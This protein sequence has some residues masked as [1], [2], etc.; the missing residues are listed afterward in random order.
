LTQ[1]LLREQWTANEESELRRR[2]LLGVGEPLDW[3]NL[4]REPRYIQAL[5][6]LAQVPQ[7]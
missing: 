7:P 5:E 1:A 4:V 2:A 3:W 6:L